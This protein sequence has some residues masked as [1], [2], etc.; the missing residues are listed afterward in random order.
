MALVVA[1]TIY[2]ATQFSFQG[3][4]RPLAAVV[5]AVALGAGTYLLIQ[6][7]LRSEEVGVALSVVRRERD[8]V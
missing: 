5:L 6:L 8:R 3:G 4:F 2:E 7:A 1:A